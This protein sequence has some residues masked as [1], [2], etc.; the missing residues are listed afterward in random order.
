M[1]RLLAGLLV[2]MLATTETT[3]A[4]IQQATGHITFLR[5]HELGSRFGPPGDEIDVE[6]VIQLGTRE[7]MSF[8][9]QLRNGP[10]LP[11]HHGM[12]D[13][14]RDAFNLDRTVTIDFD[15]QPGRKNGILVR[16]AATRAGPLAR[17]VD[18]PNIVDAR[19]DPAVHGVLD[20]A[21]LA[22]GP[23]QDE[24]P[25]GGHDLFEETRWEPVEEIQ[26][27]AGATRDFRVSVG[28]RALV[29]VHAAWKGAAVPPTVRIARGG[30]VLATGSP[31]PVPPDQGSVL[32]Q[33]RVEAAGQ[34]T[35]TLANPGPHAAYLRV[36][37]GVLPLES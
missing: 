8:G 27:P 37:V 9:F 23:P 12:L 10:S 32:A 16:A 25:S 20:P 19:Q 22:H 24:E 2:L 7:G 29:L 35:V 6:V 13:V 30:K 34:V 5:V 14:L 33:A 4:A 26:L 3:L 28:A 36:A 17:V 21:T 11:A 15:I 1:P 18:V 31:T